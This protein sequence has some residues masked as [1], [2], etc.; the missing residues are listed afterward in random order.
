MCR[1]INDSNILCMGGWMIAPILG[2]KMVDAFLE[3]R[4]TVG[5]EDWRKTWLSNAK[6]EV[7]KLE[8]EIY[9]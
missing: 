6:A 1:V 7:I 4:F 9:N 2:I 8:D 3:A 5:V